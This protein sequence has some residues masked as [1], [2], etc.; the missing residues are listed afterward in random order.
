MTNKLILWCCLIVPWFS[1]FF[2]EREA[3][4]RYIPV[5]VFT[6]LLLSILSQHAYVANWWTLKA[7][8]FPWDRITNSA[9]AYGLF[10]VATMWIFKLTYGRMWLYLLTNLCIDALQAFVFNDWMI[11]A[12]LYELN[13]LREWHLLLIMLSVAVVIY[14]FQVWLDSP[15]R[16]RYEVKELQIG[17][18]HKYFDKKAK[19]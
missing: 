14:V 17:R 16:P 8:I 12:G 4:K 10:F 15:V 13:R 5:A 19:T 3:V 18:L 9:L 6:A 2:M 7:S 1:L 11:R